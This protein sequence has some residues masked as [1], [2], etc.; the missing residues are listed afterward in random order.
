[1]LPLLSSLSLCIYIYVCVNMTNNMD[2]TLQP[3]PPKK[4]KT[5]QA[6]FKLQIRLIIYST[7]ET[8]FLDLFTFHSKLFNTL[9]V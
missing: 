3:Q 1:M 7:F 9:Y 8:I 4:T 6:V 5:H 2:V